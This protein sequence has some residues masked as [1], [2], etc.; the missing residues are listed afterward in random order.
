MKYL[1]ISSAYLAFPCSISVFLFYFR[2]QDMRVVRNYLRISKCNFAQS[3]WWFLTD[4]Y[5]NFFILKRIIDREYLASTSFMMRFEA[6]PSIYDGLNRF[7]MQL[8]RPTITHFSQVETNQKTNL[9]LPYPSWGWLKVSFSRSHW[10][11]LFSPAWIIIFS[12]GNSLNVTSCLPFV[13]LYRSSCAS[14]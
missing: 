6:R 8:A 3:P 1:V 14:N 12:S 13:L 10:L 7:I 2:T 5:C 11:I 9:T 4:R